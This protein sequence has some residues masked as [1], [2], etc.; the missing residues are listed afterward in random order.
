[1]LKFSENL[2]E[3]ALVILP[4]DGQIKIQKLLTDLKIEKHV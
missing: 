3:Y 2:N 1:M 4:H